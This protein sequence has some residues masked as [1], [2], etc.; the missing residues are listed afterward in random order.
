M[1]DADL[2]TALRTLTQQFA[3]GTGV[4]CSVQVNGIPSVV[5]ETVENELVRICQESVMNAIKHA[6]PKK[7]EVNLNYAKDHIQLEVRDDGL[8]FVDSTHARMEG[9]G[10]VSIRERT[11]Q[12][13]GEFQLKSEPNHGT[14]L[15]VKVPLRI[16]GREP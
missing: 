3:S 13:G 12:I 7:I 10:L 14:N 15:S 5:P 11:Q 8:G 6:K 9:F 1:I 16:S 4:E 2:S